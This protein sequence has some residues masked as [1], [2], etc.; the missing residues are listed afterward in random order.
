MKEEKSSKDVVQT[1]FN[2]FGSGDIQ[3]VLDTFDPEVT[4]TAVR[5]AS[6]EQG[7]HLTIIKVLKG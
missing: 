7:S 4:I 1:F 3:G 5:N 2:A 6:V